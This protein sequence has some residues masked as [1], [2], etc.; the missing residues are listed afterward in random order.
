MPPRVSLD[1]ANGNTSGAS[2]FNGQKWGRNGSP[3]TVVGSL[4]FGRLLTRQR[5]VVNRRRFGGE[6]T[7]AGA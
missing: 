4:S 3:P 7:A 6:P 5:L 1:R 2:D